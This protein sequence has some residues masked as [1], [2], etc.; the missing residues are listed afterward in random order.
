METKE[1]TIVKTQLTKAEEA[2]LAIKI[3]DQTTLEEAVGLRAKVYKVKKIITEQKEKITKPLNTALKEARA[4]FSPL[5]DKYEKIQTDID[6]KILDY[7]KKIDDEAKKKEAEIN[8][9]L[10]S[11]KMSEK[12]AE[13]KLEKIEKVENVVSNGKGA[14]QFR[15]QRVVNIKNPE[16]IP[17]KYWEINEVLVR[18]EALAGVEIPG[19]VIVEEKI[20][21]NQNLL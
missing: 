21:A 7:Q 12:T 9:K 1:L 8:A 14:I 4:M 10:E 6:D 19:V 18:K 16:L 11:G 17:D 5:E 13:K 20:I 15:T 3:K 2:V